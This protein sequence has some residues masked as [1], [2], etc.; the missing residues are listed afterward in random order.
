MEEQAIQYHFPTGT[1]LLANTPFYYYD[2]EVLRA[3]LREIKRN[4]DGYPFMV[5]YAVK[6]NGNPKIL[7]EIIKRRNG[8]RPREWRRNTRCS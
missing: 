1:T 5:H 8:C 2:M 7:K 4:I 6:A 3:T